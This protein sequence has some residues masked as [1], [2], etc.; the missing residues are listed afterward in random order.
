MSA[1]G[2]ICVGC[3]ST[4]SPSSDSNV[5]N[6]ISITKELYEALQTESWRDQYEIYDPS[7]PW[8]DA[9]LPPSDSYEDCVRHAV[10]FD[11]WDGRLMLK[12][13]QLCERRHP[14]ETER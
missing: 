8:P 4:S 10:P 13:L 6:Q 7:I 12:A 5:P 2:A 11:G 9:F 1:L 3:T 14:D